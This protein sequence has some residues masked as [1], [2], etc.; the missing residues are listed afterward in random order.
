MQQHTKHNISRHTQTIPCTHMSNSW[1]WHTLLS[2]FSPR[3]L[4]NWYGGYLRTHSLTAVYQPVI[5]DDNCLLTW[6]QKI[7]QQLQRTTIYGCP[8]LA[9]LATRQST[10]AGRIWYTLVNSPSV[11]ITDSRGTDTSWHLT[12]TAAKSRRVDRSSL[13]REAE[14]SQTITLMVNTSVRI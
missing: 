14:R 7:W 9:L 4:F 11:H 12:G 5:S 8:A 2:D 10:T 3:L 1:Y 6:Y 13:C